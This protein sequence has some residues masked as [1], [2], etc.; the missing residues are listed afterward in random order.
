MPRQ[1]RAAG[2]GRQEPDSSIKDQDGGKYLIQEMEAIAFGPG[3]GWLS[4]K[5]PSPV[6]NKIEDRGAYIERMGD[7]FVGVGYDK[8]G[9]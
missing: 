8:S 2:I 1:W 9:G 6:S 3:S 4:Y 7:Y 5:W